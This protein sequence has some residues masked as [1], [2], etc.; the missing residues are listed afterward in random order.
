MPVVGPVAA[1]S[2]SV[3]A[4]TALVALVIPLVTVI[5]AVTGAAPGVVSAPRI[6]GRR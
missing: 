2:L 6:F 5:T 3:V 1:A 4:T